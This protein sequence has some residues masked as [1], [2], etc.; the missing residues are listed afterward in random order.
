MDVRFIE[1]YD[2]GGKSAVTFLN[3]FIRSHGSIKVLDTK[4][5]FDN[6]GLV[7]ILAR[8]SGSLDAIARLDLEYQ[9]L[10]DSNDLDVGMLM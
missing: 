7:S 9:N 1:F 2:L 6:E 5:A 3:E 8:V 10:I 4:F